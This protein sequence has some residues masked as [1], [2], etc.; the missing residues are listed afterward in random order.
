MHRDDALSWFEI[1]AADL[2]RATRFYERVLG[3]PL[4]SETIGPSTLS[5]FSYQRPGVGGCVIAGNGQVPASSGTV[6]YLNAAPKIDDAL[7]RVAAA[8]GKVVLPKTALP[9]DMGFF[10]HMIDTEG[11]RVGLHALS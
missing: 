4:K 6:I 10:A 3:R 9:G 11:N 2:G 1:P 5:V 7:S 8:G